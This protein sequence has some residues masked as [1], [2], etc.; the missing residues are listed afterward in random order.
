MTWFVGAIAKESKNNWDLCKEV[1]LFGISTAGR[2]HK[3]G[4]VKKGDKLVIWMSGQG[5]IS[6]CEATGDS[7]IPKDKSETPWPGSQYRF[8]LVVP[9]KIIHELTEPKFLNFVDFKQV[10]T[11][12]S[13]FSI[14]RGF[15]AIPDEVGLKILNVITDASKL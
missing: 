9:I 15:C 11:G 3:V 13:Q 7:R 1:G 10:E 8:G 12:M 6:Y 2:Q 4:R 14:R 5:W